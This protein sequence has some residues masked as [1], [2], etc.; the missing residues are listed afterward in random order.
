MLQR[1]SSVTGGVYGKTYTYRDT[2]T[3]NTTTQVAGL[4]YDLPT[5]I[6][7]GYTYDVLGNIATYTQ[8][9]TTYTYTYDAQNQLL[10]QVGGGKTYTYT[11]D[12]AGNILTSSDGTTSHS[13][14]YGNSVWKDLLTAV[15]GHTISYET[16]S[17]NPT[18]Y[19][20]GT[21]WTF[22]WAEGRRLMSASGGGKSISYTYD[23]E[24]LR[25]SKKVG[26][27]E[28][29]YYYAGGKLMRETW[30]SNTLDFFYDAMGTPYAIK[31]NGTL[32]YY[33]TNLQGDVLH[34]V[35]TSG[36]P[37]VSYTYSPYG[38]V[39]STTGTLAST[40]GADNPLRYRSY[41]YDIDSGL[42][43]LQSR[44]YDPE[45]G[46]F[47]NADSYAST[48][49]GIIGHNMFAYCLNNPI[50]NFDPQ[51]TITITVTTLI[52]IISAIVG[53]GS[54]GYTAYSGYKA[55]WELGDILWYAFGA[56]LGGFLTVY[57]LGMSAYQVYINYCMLNGITPVTVIS[58]QSN[59]T[60]QLQKCAK[61]ANSKVS[62]SG[63]V[64]GTKKHSAFT[65]EVNN[66][67]DSSLRT[68]VSYL[69]GE[70]VP[71]GTKG[72]VRFDV[73]QY[74]SK[75]NPVAA[76]DFK[77]GSATLTQSRIEEMQSISGLNIPIYEIK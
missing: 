76:W 57:T 45:L 5:D 33:I 63:P 41:Y 55:G 61:N 46:R 34:I 50:G 40:L 25:L 3:T 70:E 35:N 21:S 16:G 23:S 30:G 56:G 47:I 10:K 38:K 32:Y 42:Y 73:I 9:G 44:Y 26:T 53:A 37:V 17:G 77:T 69:N 59:V 74:D 72:S 68:E 20:N 7:Y 1:L 39:L 31:Y 51:G 6:T 60:S 62:G 12:A 27:T 22:G 13:Y 65:N 19:Y 43:Y 14:T 4:T 18:G 54:A 67:G 49:Q 75:G 52:L 36:T 66:L 15:D 48:G 11:Y 29:K 24:G 28:H 64:A 8:G 71:Y 2:S 58:S